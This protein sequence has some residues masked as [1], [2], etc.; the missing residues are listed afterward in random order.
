MEKKRMRKRTL[1][2]NIILLTGVLLFFLFLAIREEKQE[3]LTL[4]SV[5]VYADNAVETIEPW[6]NEVDGKHYFFLPAFAG[7]SEAYEEL[8][9]T[10]G[11][12]F[13][14]SENIPAVFVTTESGSMAYLEEDKEN[15]ETGTISI[16]CADG[17]MEYNGTLERISGRGNTSWEKYSKKP[18]TI[19]LKEAAPLLEMGSGKKW[20]LLPVWREGS[21]MNT[22]IVFDMAEALG[23]SYTPECTWI[24][25][26]FNGE[27]AGNYLLCESVSVGKGRVDIY[28]LEKENQVLNDNIREAETF[29]LGNRKGYEIKSS[30]D[31]TGGYLIEK[32]L[33]DYYVSERCGFVT[34]AGKQFTIGAPK[35]A[36]EEQ[37]VYIA[38]YVQQIEDMILAH[39]TAY[40]AYIDMGSFAGRFLVDEI[41]LNCDANITS[42]FF[43]KDKDDALLYAGP[44]WDYDGAMGEV[45]SGWL[46]G[47]GVDY[48]GSITEPFRNESDLLG[49]Y[50]SM[51]EDEVFYEEVRALYEES[52]PG[53]QTLLEN[54]ID[55][56]AAQ[57]LASANMDF[58]RWQNENKKDDYPGH[59]R[60]YENNVRYLKYFLANRLNYL[61]ERWGID[62]EVFEVPKS[63]E[64]HQVVF[65]NGESIVEIRAVQDGD[66]I[67]EPPELDGERYWGWYYE[68]SNEKLR[69]KIPVYEDIVLF[70]REK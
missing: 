38:D 2:I 10:Y 13:L 57:I 17:S 11:A 5:E 64:Q 25:L 29:D 62:Y 66:V 35:H 52:L 48:T 53:L 39:D 33:P 55:E 12:E 30:S 68:H 45:N 59:Y 63:G 20:Y 6:Y 22:K 60:N 16:I 1:L 42:M 15:E 8:E 67:T 41:S 28:D 9:E 31:V 40:T 49:W 23:L 69:D 70:A 18:Y 46:E 24:D 36:S 58:I 4:P 61:N 44:V 43:Y 47:H 54:R 3:S 65:K 26:Y 50:E 51:Y 27:Y 34:D 19:S 32:D 7:K 21:R 14:Q 56:Y 37:V